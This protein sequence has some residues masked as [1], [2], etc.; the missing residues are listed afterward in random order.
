[1]EPSRARDTPSS[2]LADTVAFLSTTKTL[3]GLPTSVLE[4]LARRM[5]AR[6]FAPGEPLMEQ[7]HEGNSMMV[8][9]TGLV[10]VSIRDAEG[11][12]TV[13]AQPGVGS[14]MGEMALLTK[15]PR[16]ADVIALAEVDALVLAGDDFYALVKEYPDLAVVLTYLV[17][18]R[19]GQAPTDGLKDKVLGGYQLKRRLGLG[20]TAVV[21]S[22]VQ[23]ETEMVV[24][25]KMLS[26]RLAFDE[27]A[28]ERFHQEL[29]IVE[30][31]QHPNVARVYGRFE[32]FATW[33]MALEHCDGEDISK[34]L[35]AN[36]PMFEHDARAVVG[37]TA[38]ALRHVH[39]KGIVH[40]DMKPANVMINLDGTVK[41]MDFGI[42]L[43]PPSDT[44]VRAAGD[45]LFSGTP[46]YMAPEQFRMVKGDPRVDIYALGCVA[47]ECL[48]CFPPFVTDNFAELVQMKMSG[49]VE[50]IE[51]LRPD[52]SKEFCDFINAALA[53]QVDDR[54]A[55]LDAVCEWA[56]PVDPALVQVAKDYVE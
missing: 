26:H 12:M 24:A 53:V 25:L 27:S 21:Y 19:L 54:L 4:H 10:Q 38:R 43:P 16:S 3:A 35:A 17:A 55:D 31:L 6:H 47:Y 40:K 44:D 50:P 48:T 15:E 1:M 42:A 29:D 56:T 11:V 14:V 51:E 33:F 8:I 41:L 7:G 22:A 36:G 18:E 5:E 23:V 13:L 28:I 45:G 49:K 30:Q 37:Q 52:V 34:V 9:R 32:G 39:E 46:R 20:A 2:P